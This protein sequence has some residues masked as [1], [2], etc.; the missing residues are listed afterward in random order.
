[1]TKQQKKSDSVGFW[2]CLDLQKLENRR[3]YFI[4]HPKLQNDS[5][6]AHSVRIWPCFD[7]QKLENRRFYFKMTH[8]RPIPFKASQN[9]ARK[10]FK[11]SKN[12]WID[13]KNARI[14]VCMYI[15]K[16]SE[17]IYLPSLFFSRE[18]RRLKVVNLFGWWYHLP[19]TT[20]FFPCP[21]KCLTKNRRIKINMYTYVYISRILKFFYPQSKMPNF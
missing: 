17:R 1:M 20:Y 21:E 19:S 4:S 9:F 16:F 6:A 8:L 14:Y 5:P 2:P 15:N 18:N 3:F 12:S 11:K 13:L 10:V 7:L